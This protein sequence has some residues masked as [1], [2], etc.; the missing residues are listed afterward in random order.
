[1][2][3]L[4]TWYQNP[5]NPPNSNT[6]SFA[7][8]QPIVSFDPQNLPKS[9]PL[10]LTKQLRDDDRI[11]EGLVPAPVGP[12]LVAPDNLGRVLLFEGGSMTAI[13]LWKVSSA[14][15]GAASG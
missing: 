12:L 14:A 2:K 7:T 4:S 15:V 8:T 3:P 11:V 1:M 5:Y 6:A 9:E 10:S 13:R